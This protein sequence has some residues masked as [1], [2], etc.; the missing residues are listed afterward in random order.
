MGASLVVGW[1]CVVQQ[2][3]A[4][5]G[6]PTGYER[7]LQRE[8]QL[9]LRGADR[10]DRKARAALGQREAFAQC[11]GMPLDLLQRDR[12]RQLAFEGD[13]DQRPAWLSPQCGQVLMHASAC[14]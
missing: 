8:Q 13:I 6:A 5:M 14:R 11:V 7:S 10:R 4:P 3:V 9:P 1:R 12:P 2:Q